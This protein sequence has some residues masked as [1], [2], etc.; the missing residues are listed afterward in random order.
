VYSAAARDTYAT[1]VP[2][3]AGAV[4]D[5]LA[6]AAAAYANAAAREPTDWRNH[7]GAAWAALDLLLARGYVENWSVGTPGPLGQPRDLLGSFADQHDW[8]ALLGAG[9]APEAGRA[10]QSLAQE[11]G[12]VRVAQKYRNMTASEL[13]AAAWGSIRAADERNPLEPA[14]DETIQLMGRLSTN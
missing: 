8:S 14:I 4:L 6:L 3:R 1:Q 10:A 2:D 11:E 5:D 12:A 9:P 13:A 7:Y